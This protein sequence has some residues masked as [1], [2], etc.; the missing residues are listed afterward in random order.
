[1]NTSTRQNL[2]TYLMNRF[3]FDLDDLEANRQGKHSERQA[4]VYT[5]RTPTWSIAFSIGVCA[6]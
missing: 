5:D 3:E 1:M 4:K 2:A 6:S